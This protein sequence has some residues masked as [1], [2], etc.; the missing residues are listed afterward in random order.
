MSLR[1]LKKKERFKTILMHM[2]ETPIRPNHL[3]L[4]AL[5][6]GVL[7]YLGSLLSAWLGFVLFALSFL[8]DALDGWYARELNLQTRMGAFLDGVV[9]RIVEFSML[10]AL[11]HFDA[12]PLWLE[13]NFLLMIN[14]F[15][16]TCMTSYIKAYAI[17]KRTVPIEIQ[18]A[19]DK[20]FPCIYP[21]WA[22]VVMF[23]VAYVLLFINPIFA[24]AVLLVSAM[25]AFMASLQGLIFVL[26]VG[27]G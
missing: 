19:G 13:K 5:L 12:P 11:W 24:T 8:L 6:F 1:G 4:G 22:R 20:S 18:K 9:D 14:L 27:E 10:L 21:R 23:L 26:H 25:L 15:F 16:G 7:G 3:T 2:Q 17:S